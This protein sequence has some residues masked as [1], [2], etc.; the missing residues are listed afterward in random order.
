LNSKEIKQEKEKQKDK[1][2]TVLQ[3]MQQLDDRFFYN[4]ENRA[5]SLKM[6]YIEQDDKQDN[7]IVTKD[8]IDSL[9]KVGI[10]VE[11]SPIKLIDLK[12]KID[13]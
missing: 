5:F 12:K 10:K 1:Q 9:E 3:E 4:K 2:K 7:F 13:A 11:A 6:Y 8:I